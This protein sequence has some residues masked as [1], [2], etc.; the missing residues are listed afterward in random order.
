MPCHLFCSAEVSGSILQTMRIGR[1]QSVCAKSRPRC[2]LSESTY[3]SQ[4]LSQQLDIGAM[5][6]YIETALALS[7]CDCLFGVAAFH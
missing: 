1:A 2:Q 6:S 7:S 5:I 3:S 4:T